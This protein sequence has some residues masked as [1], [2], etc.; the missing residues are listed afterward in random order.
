MVKGEDKLLWVCDLCSTQ[1]FEP[2][3]NVALTG[4]GR[5]KTYVLGDDWPSVIVRHDML[6]ANHDIVTRFD[7]F[8]IW[9]IDCVLLHDL[10]DDG[11]W[12]GRDRCEQ[13]GVRLDPPQG[14]ETW[15]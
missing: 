9:K 2:A 15:C 6:W 11:L 3:G 1:G 8:F 12:D 5:R 10:F 7:H 4:R 13:T 14:R